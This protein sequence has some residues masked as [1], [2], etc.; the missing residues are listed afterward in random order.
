MDTG[1]MRRIRRQR[2]RFGFC[3]R[4][5]GSQVYQ[6][7][8]RQWR[9][10]EVVERPPRERADE[11]PYSHSTRLGKKEGALGWDAEGSHFRHH[12]SRQWKQGELSWKSS[13]N[14]RTEVD[15]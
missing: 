7:R 10:D 3:D 6:G 14:S 11:A 15:D 2:P 4:R 13:V 8:L 5:L 9:G 1:A 12:F